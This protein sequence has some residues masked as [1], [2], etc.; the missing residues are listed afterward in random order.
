MVCHAPAAGVYCNSDGERLTCV[1]KTPC[2][3]SYQARLQVAIYLPA[4]CNWCPCRD[5]HSHQP[6]R[7]RTGASHIPKHP[8]RFAVQ[9]QTKLLLRCNDPEFQAGPRAPSG[10]L[11]SIQ[12]LD[13]TGY[14]QVRWCLSPVLKPGGAG[15]MPHAEAGAARP[16]A[17]GSWYP[18]EQDLHAAG[19]TGWP[20]AHRHLPILPRTGALCAEGLPGCSPQTCVCARLTPT[21]W[22]GERLLRVPQSESHS[23]GEAGG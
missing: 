2:Y 20:T 9:G 1:D 22:L 17:A 18:W 7:C 19:R 15:R 5:Q 13:Q 23:A 4:C 12:Y 6:H 14:G 10:C 8:W 16:F 21:H 3:M 11:K